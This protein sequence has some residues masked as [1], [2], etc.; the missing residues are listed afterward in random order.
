MFA[1]GLRNGKG[2]N[3][4]EA[5]KMKVHAGYWFAGLFGAIFIGI[6][7]AWLGEMIFPPGPVSNVVGSLCMIALAVYACFF[8]IKRFAILSVRRA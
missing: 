5:L 7:M 2:M 3:A 4:P 6:V 1:D 8:W